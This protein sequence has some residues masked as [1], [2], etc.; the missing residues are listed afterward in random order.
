MLNWLLTQVLPLTLLLSA[1]LLV[2][3][4]ALRWLGARWQYS[5]WLAV[6]L[7]LLWPLLPWQLSPVADTA[8]YQVKLNM[9][10]LSSSLAE[11]HLWSLLLLGLWLIGIGVMV[12]ALWH[13]YQHIRQQLR[14]AGQFTAA[15]TPLA[16]KQSHG[17]QGPYVTGLIRP[18]VLLPVDFLQRFDPEQQ[19]LIL[20][21]ELTHWRR[22]DLHANLVALLVLTLFWFHPLCWLAYRAYRQDQELACDALVLASASPQQK[23]AYSY[24]LLHS[25]ESNV[26]SSPAHWKLLT[27][28]YGD[29]KMM[30]QRLQLLQRQQGFSKTAL[31]LTLSALV[32]ATLWLQQP[33]HAAGSVEDIK[34]VM[35]V[36]PRYPI[37]AVEARIEG[38][39]VA[40]FDI[41]PD[42]RVQNIE[43]VKSMPEQVFDKTSVR[44]LQQ[45]VYSPSATGFK[46]AR[47]QLDFAM[48]P[49][50]ADTE[51]VEVT[52]QH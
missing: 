16:C 44:A 20:Q 27:N 50:P 33:V 11:G 3:P 15:E 21:H 24:A 7:S 10:Q 49:V 25:L 1:L 8:V 35:R 37:K 45:W 31:A 5:L 36:E 38:Y 43:I 52:P 26:H 17:Q 12:V 23:I 9:H 32:G 18:T 42:G 40:E 6:P 30:K 41:Q 22:G 48:D 46:K 29:K 39:V 19:Q 34:P 47:V 51:R 4:F 13:Q 28:H 2:R 14:A